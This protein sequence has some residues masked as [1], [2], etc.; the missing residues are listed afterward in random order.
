MRSK[1][2]SVIV[3]ST[4]IVIIVLILVAVIFVIFVA[5]GTL[6]SG[7]KNKNSKEAA[8]DF[9]K[10]PPGWTKT[11]KGFIGSRQPKIALKQ[12]RYTANTEEK[13][14]PDSDNPIR[15]ATF[16]LKAGSA[17]IEYEDDTEDAGELEEQNCPLP[18][19]DNKDDIKVCSIV[20]L[21]KG[22]TLTINCTGQS[23]CRVDVEK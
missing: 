2:R 23:G 6:S 7:P 9:T 1:H 11:I 15:T 12:D 22:G 13:I 17:S 14:P 16:R 10:N 4:K 5:T 8:K 18:N 20:A 21:K 3:S 19:F